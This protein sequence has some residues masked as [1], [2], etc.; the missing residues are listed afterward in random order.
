MLNPVTN[1]YYSKKLPENAVGL[2]SV[3]ST[4][5]TAGLNNREFLVAERIEPKVIAGG[6]C[7]VLPNAQIPLGC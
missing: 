3:K 1:F 4:P 5:I 6:I 2:I 7:Q